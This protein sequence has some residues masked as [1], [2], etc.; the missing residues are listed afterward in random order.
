MNLVSKDDLIQIFV[1]N[2]FFSRIFLFDIIIEVSQFTCE[3][4][5]YYIHYTIIPLIIYRLLTQ[6]TRILNI[7]HH[8]QF[9]FLV[10]T[11]T[12]ESFA[13]LKYLMTFFE[14]PADG[15]ALR[16]SLFNQFFFLL[17]KTVPSR[18]NLSFCLFASPKPSYLI[19]N[20]GSGVGYVP[21]RYNRR[22]R[23]VIFQDI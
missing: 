3:V 16:C 18:G 4:K 21:V 5:H 7:T 9:S 2:L 20:P 6:S 17:Y 22:S 1:L 11:I 13:E 10:N 8:L 23:C 19:S 12:D 15:E 14:A